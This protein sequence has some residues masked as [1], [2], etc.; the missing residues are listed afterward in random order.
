M[1]LPRPGLA[2][3]EF[4]SNLRAGAPRPMMFDVRSYVVR[5]S[6]AATKP[7]EGGVPEPRGPFVSLKCRVFSSD[8]GRLILNP[9][10]AKS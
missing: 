5:L 1:A 3:K 2:S 7:A 10:P 4:R 6:H 8:L 9:N